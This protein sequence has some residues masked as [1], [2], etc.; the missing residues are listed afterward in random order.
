M[1]CYFSSIDSCGNVNWTVVGENYVESFEMWR[2]RRMEIRRMDRLKNEVLNR[3]KEEMTSHY[4]K[5]EGR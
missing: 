5:I 2:W 4:C 3:V 1:K